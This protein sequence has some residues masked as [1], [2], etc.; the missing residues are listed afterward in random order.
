[1]LTD[2]WAA[3][4]SLLVERRLVASE[5]FADA[6]T[7][8]LYASKDKEVATDLIM[9][10]ALGSGRRVLF[11][12]ILR[13]AHELS[14]V[15][16]DDPATLAPGAFG[17]LEPTGSE[18]VPVGSLG[19]ALICVPG[20]AFSRDGYRLGRGGGYYDRLLAE[21]APR[22]QS[23][24]LAYAFQV[25]DRVPRSPSDVRLNLIVS[26]SALYRVDAGERATRPQPDQG[27]SRC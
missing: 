1:M 21:A 12:K 13:E 18:T 11:P 19:R 6:A 10:E 16:V 26:E 4:H 8:V 7:V 22:A 2:A 14:L 15:E 25:L 23:V 24:G 27:G 17:L 9:S 5:V 3:S 20:L